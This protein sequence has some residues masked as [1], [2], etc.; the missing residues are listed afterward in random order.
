MFKKFSP[1]ADIAGQTILKS[2]AQRT[3]RTNL[4]A[5]WQIDQEVLDTAIWPKKESLVLVK[6]RDHLSIFTLHGQP[7][8]FQHFDGPFVPTL[9]LLHK[10][11]TLVPALRVDRGAIRFLL[12]GAN[13]MCPGF[14]S[15]GG[16]LPEPEAA[17]P[18]GRVVSIEAEGKEHAAAIGITKLST[19]DIKTVN[20][21]VAVEI[22][23]FLGDDLW[24]LET[25]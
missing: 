6:G 20:K 3:I 8:F 12:A 23:T 21:G 19:E 22:A 4:L 9:R 10:F 25:I 11:P 1:A 16:R 18:A 13:M 17:L 15:N 5:Q 14:T 2:S 24:T 7:L